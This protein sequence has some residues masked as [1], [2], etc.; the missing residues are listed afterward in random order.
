MGDLARTGIAVVGTAAAISLT[1]TTSLL[2]YIGV[3]CV[4]D[5]RAPKSAPRR[6]GG[7]QFV[8]SDVGASAL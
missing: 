6:S 8:G 4:G 5:L 2:T 7:L 3:Q 1:A